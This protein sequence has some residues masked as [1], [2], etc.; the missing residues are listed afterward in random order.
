ME[1]LSINTK[2]Y[3]A[4]FSKTSSEAVLQF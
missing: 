2:R 1:Q 4:H 3:D